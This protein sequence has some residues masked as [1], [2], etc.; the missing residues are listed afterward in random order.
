[1]SSP[2]PFNVRTPEMVAFA[3][4]QAEYRDFI[5]NIAMDE[6]VFSG[7]NTVNDL[8]ELSDEDLVLV[9]RMNPELLEQALPAIRQHILADVQ[10]ECE[11]RTERARGSM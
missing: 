6:P 9:L 5:W 1:M 7:F 4:I 8:P 10:A 3:A 11:R 2:S